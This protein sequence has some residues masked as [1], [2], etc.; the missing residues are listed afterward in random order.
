MKRKSVFLFL[1]ISIVLSL[2][3]SQEPEKKPPINFT[4]ISIKASNSNKERI[5]KKV[6]ADIITI[7]QSLYKFN[8]Y[9]EI[10]RRNLKVTEGEKETASL[11]N[12]LTFEIEAKTEENNISA[13]IIIKDKNKEELVNTTI[14]MQKGKKVI[15]GGWSFNEDTMIIVIKAS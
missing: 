3:F 2:V 9:E 12:S 13:K 8:T 1:I 7:L 15:L 6:D 4:I 10:S 11:P 14:E 5:T